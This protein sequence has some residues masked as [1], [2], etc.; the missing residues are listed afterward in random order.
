MTGQ[1]NLTIAI[2]IEPNPFI[3]GVGNTDEKTEEKRWILTIPEVTIAHTLPLGAKLAIF[4]FSIAL[5]FF[6][7]FIATLIYKVP[8]ISTK[9]AILVSLF[10]GALGLEVL[11]AKKIKK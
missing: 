6:A 4:L 11:V 8:L 10:A 9:F 1:K 3:V 5:L 2:P 7:I